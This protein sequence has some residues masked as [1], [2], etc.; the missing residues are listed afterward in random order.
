MF[1]VFQ[2]VVHSLGAEAAGVAVQVCTTTAESGPSVVWPG[3]K[4][5]PIAKQDQRSAMTDLYSQSQFPE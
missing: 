1:Q 5:A 2:N 3:R 4:S